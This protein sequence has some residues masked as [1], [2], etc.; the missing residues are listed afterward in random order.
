VFTLCSQFIKEI[1]NM[2]TSNIS[3]SNL[4]DATLNPRKRKASLPQECPTKGFVFIHNGKVVPSQLDGDYYE[5]SQKKAKPAT[6]P[7][8]SK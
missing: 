7:N 2:S 5:G 6:D 8:T 1:N 4:G 3:H